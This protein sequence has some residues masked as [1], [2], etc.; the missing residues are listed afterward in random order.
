MA[1]KVPRYPKDL[2]RISVELAEKY[3]EFN[4]DCSRYFEAIPVMEEAEFWKILPAYR[5]VVIDVAF[6][7]NYRCHPADE[8]FRRA[9]TGEG[10]Y[11]LSRAIQFA[12]SW[13]EIDSR[14]AWELGRAER[15]F[16]ADW[17]RSDDSFGDLCDSLPLA[18]SSCLQALREGRVKDEATLHAS[19]DAAVLAVP[20]FVPHI[21]YG[22]NYNF[23]HLHNE[24]KNRLRQDIVGKERERRERDG[25][26]DRGLSFFSVEV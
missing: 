22:E 12:R 14:F 20:S 9:V 3:T 4:R 8:F 11:S 16:G 6:R 19:C 7:K 25:T 26:L 24:A 13:D 21:F 1:T 5:S 10:K 17:G 18:G 23:M 2:V 15:E